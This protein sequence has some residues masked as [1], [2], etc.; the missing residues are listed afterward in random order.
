MM[1]AVLEKVLGLRP[2][3]VP[4]AQGFV[5]GGPWSMSG[6]DHTVVLRI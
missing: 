1:L 5:D 4:R 6:N 2:R 3:N